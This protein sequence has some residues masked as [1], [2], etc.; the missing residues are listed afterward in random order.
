LYGTF[1]IS[2]HAGKAII[3]WGAFFKISDKKPAGEFAIQ[4]NAPRSKAKQCRHAT[5]VD[6]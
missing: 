1:R 2:T 3:Y 5:A 6:H 4:K